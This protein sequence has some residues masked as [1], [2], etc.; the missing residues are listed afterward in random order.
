MRDDSGEY[1]IYRLYGVDGNR[2][3]FRISEPM[4]AFAQKVISGIEA[5]PHGIS[6][7]GISVDTALIRFG[8]EVQ[9]EQQDS[10]D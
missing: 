5:L 8:P 1:R 4:R 6:V 2:A 3:K 7:D 10:I 9:L